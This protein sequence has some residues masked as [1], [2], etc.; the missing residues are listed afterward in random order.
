MLVLILAAMVVVSLV[1]RDTQQ[2][3]NEREKGK[4]IA[5]ALQEDFE[6]RRQPPLRFPDVPTLSRERNRYYFN[7][8]YADR[9][10]LYSEVGVCC[11]KT[12]V[13]LFVRA[14]G[15]IVI[16]Y[17]GDQYRSQWIPEAEFCARAVELGLTDVMK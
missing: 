8:F 17:D 6:P 16:L 12:P 13:R 3:R 15:R 1:N 9:K 4:L 11:L 7:L 2:I 5:A 14:E 10:K